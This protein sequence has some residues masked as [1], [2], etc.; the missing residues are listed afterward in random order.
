MNTLGHNPEDPILTV[1]L[2]Y[3]FA[4]QEKVAKLV[5]A[6][7]AA[8]VEV[9]AFSETEKPAEII[10]EW[11]KEGITEADCL[12]FIVSNA[13]LTR[14]D[15]V[16]R[17]V[18]MAIEWLVKNGTLSPT[19]IPMRLKEDNKSI[20]RVE[21]QPRNFDTKKPIGKPII[22]DELNC[23]MIDR[24]GIDKTIAEFLKHT[25]PQTTII[26]HTL[27]DRKSKL[28]DSA[29][30]A[31]EE[32]LPDDSVRDQPEDIERWIQE[33][34]NE[35]G[36]LN[37][38]C[39]W[40]NV[41]AVHH[42]GGKV[43]GLLWCSLHRRSGI[44]FVA[45]WGLL[46]ASRGYSR[47]VN[48]VMSIVKQ[49]REWAPN[50]QAL[51]FAA[52]RV[53]WNI[54]DKFLED[55]S[56]IRLSH[57]RR[58]TRHEGWYKKLAEPLNDKPSAIVQALEKANSTTLNKLIEQLRHFRRFNLFTVGGFKEKFRRDGLISCAFARRDYI[59]NEYSPAKKIMAD[60]VQPPIHLPVDDLHANHLWMFGL[61][62]DPQAHSPAESIDWFYDVYLKDFLG[63]GKNRIPQWNN[64]MVH[65]KARWRN[66]F[67]EQAELKEL[68]IK[69]VVSRYKILL[70]VVKRYLV[71][72]R[73]AKG[74][75]QRFSIEL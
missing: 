61:F 60:F 25:T 35:N 26:R 45:F 63:E 34:W 13:S 16:E 23:M 15:Y 10:S 14:H 1:F 72:E 64:Y 28:F 56:A 40:I 20:D 68:R 48:F 44:G 12:I 4:D 66:P 19:V 52:E 21:F 43:I 11:I 31:Y 46:V 73:N 24:D 39:S 30:E 33:S 29:M 53:Q 2:S 54:M 74:K 47:G 18:G 32:L 38:N 3:S 71:H 42:I 49:M 67:L 59:P 62:A 27:N 50:M 36:E 70:D 37:N 55:A 58:K 75:N 22:W 9:H 65:F 57:L 8:N 17:E 6:L 7:Q 51:L 69:E 5:D 41:L